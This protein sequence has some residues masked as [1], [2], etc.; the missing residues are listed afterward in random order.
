MIDLLG[1]A[2]LNLIY[3]LIGVLSLA[4]TFQLFNKL[5]PHLPFATM[6]KEEETAI[7]IAIVIA[8]VILGVANIISSALN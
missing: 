1:I 3:A 5:T 4:V 2:G 8:A 7:G 6:L